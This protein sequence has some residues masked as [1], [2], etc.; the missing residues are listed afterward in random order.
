MDEVLD[1]VVVGAGQAGLGVSYYL[2]DEGRK[3]VVYERGRIGETW[4]S[5]RWDSFQLNTINI[6]N[7]LPGLPYRGTEPDGFWRQDELVA[8]FQEYVEHFNLERPHKGLGHRRPVEP[9]TPSC[10][11]GPIVCRERLGGL[12]KS[13]QRDAA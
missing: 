11:D 9:I 13:Y 5:Q 6:M 3:H 7:A 2:Q 1:T 12:L 8:Y 10:R 4:L